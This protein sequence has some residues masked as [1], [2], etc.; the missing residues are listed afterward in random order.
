MNSNE[1]FTVNSTILP[2]WILRN[3]GRARINFYVQCTVDWIELII[4]IVTFV[5]CLF[6]EW[7]TY[8]LMSDYYMRC[9]FLL[10]LIRENEY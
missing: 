7:D 2:E 6:L 9:A 5:F 1:N 3:G 4:M 10:L 8:K